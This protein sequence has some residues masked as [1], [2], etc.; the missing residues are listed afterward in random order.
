MGLD[1]NALPLWPGCEGV[2][3]KTEPAWAALP[4]SCQAETSEKSGKDSV[5]ADAGLNGPSRPRT[6]K[7]KTRP[8]ALGRD[9]FF[10]RDD[11]VVTVNDLKN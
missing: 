4:F 8:M 2:T 10:S 5:K 1:K 9:V 6:L 3:R 7:P 11:M